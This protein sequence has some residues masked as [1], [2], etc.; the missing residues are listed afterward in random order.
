MGE[1]GAS[2]LST[3]QR[4]LLKWLSICGASRP[5]AVKRGV[6]TAA[7]FFSVSFPFNNKPCLRRGRPGQTKENREKRIAAVAA[8]KSYFSSGFPPHP[9][10]CKVNCVA[11]RAQAFN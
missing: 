10:L 2:F 3:N 9:K 6:Q 4:V 8:Q 5:F 11:A 1:R 7:V